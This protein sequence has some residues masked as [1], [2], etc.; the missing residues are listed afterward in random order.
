MPNCGTDNGPNLIASSI[1]TRFTKKS[2]LRGKSL[3]R[4]LTPLNS[5]IY[6][7]EMPN[8]RAVNTNSA[9]SP[10]YHYELLL[11]VPIFSM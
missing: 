1:K 10:P 7:T 11:D 8:A 3:N 5:L 4:T 9:I 2:T 6:N